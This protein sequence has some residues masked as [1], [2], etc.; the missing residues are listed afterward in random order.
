MSTPRFMMSVTRSQIRI[1]DADVTLAKFVL[2]GRRFLMGLCPTGGHADRQE[3]RHIRNSKCRT[4]QHCADPMSND[5]PH[6]RLGRRFRAFDALPDLFLET[7][8][9]G[10]VWAPFAEHLTECL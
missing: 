5:H 6:R 1:E 4:R 8:R 7:R 2:N 10:N 9:K 3:L